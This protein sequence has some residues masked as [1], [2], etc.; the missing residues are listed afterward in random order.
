[1]IAKKKVSKVILL[2]HFNS[3]AALTRL[4]TPPN[5]LPILKYEPYCN[6]L[7][8]PELVSP[9]SSSSSSSISCFIVSGDSG[10]APLGFLMGLF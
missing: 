5:G 8:M 4:P 6:S 1:M 7:P 3:I 2:S 10:L 9:N